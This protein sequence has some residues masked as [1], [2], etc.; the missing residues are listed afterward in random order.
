[1]SL[2]GIEVMLIARSGKQLSLK[3]VGT[4]TPNKSSHK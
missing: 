2:E 3:R 1:M 4:I